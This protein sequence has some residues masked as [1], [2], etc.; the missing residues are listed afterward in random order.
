ML[1]NIC[2]DNDPQTPSP[3]P[4]ITYIKISKTTFEGEVY[5]FL[6]RE[7]AF[8]MADRQ[9]SGLA[10]GYLVWLDTA[11]EHLLFVSNNSPWAFLFV[12]LLQLAFLACTG[13]R[14]TLSE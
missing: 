9:D 8:A 1:G 12:K 5:T 11:P 2:L 7:L 14:G 3:T 6:F 13:R 4:Q 10:W